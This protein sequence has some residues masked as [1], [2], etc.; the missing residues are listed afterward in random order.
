MWPLIFGILILLVRV[1]PAEGSIR[2]ITVYPDHPT[3]Q[4]S[5]RVTVFGDFPDGCWRLDKYSCQEGRNIEVY[6]VDRYAPGILCP[7]ESQNYVAICR[8]GPLPAG[9]YG[10]VATEYHDSVRLPDP[11]SLILFFMVA[12]ITPNERVAWG[13]IKARYR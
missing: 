7:V 6:T 5:L 13:T 2:S 3:P 12:P 11:D 1:I 9:F 4:D 8:Y 10:V